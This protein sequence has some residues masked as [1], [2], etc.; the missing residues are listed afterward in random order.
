MKTPCLPLPSICGAEK[1]CLTF[2]IFPMMLMK[3][4][5][6]GHKRKLSTG[7][8]RQVLVWAQNLLELQWLEPPLDA[9]ALQG[10]CAVQK[11]P[12]MPRV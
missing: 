10:S 7:Q 1:F 6:W 3:D 11:C 4:S 5:G 8:G 12:G 2:P 9:S